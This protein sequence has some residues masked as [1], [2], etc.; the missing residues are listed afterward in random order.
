MSEKLSNATVRLSPLKLRTMLHAEIV[1][2]TFVGV[3][4]HVRHVVDYTKHEHCLRLIICQLY[5]SQE[6]IILIQNKGALFSGILFNFVIYFSQ[7][8]FST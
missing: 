6:V 7:P 5:Q 2:T 3:S 4:L 1:F 8:F